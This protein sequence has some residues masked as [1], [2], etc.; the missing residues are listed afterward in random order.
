MESSRKGGPRGPFEN[1]AKVPGDH[2]GGATPVPI[3]NTEVKTTNADGTWGAAPW[4]SRTSPGYSLQLQ[5]PVPWWAA[6]AFARS[7][8][9]IGSRDMLADMASG[10]GR[11][12]GPRGP[13]A[14][15]A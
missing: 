7:E 10:S 9:Q 15:A 5:R 1:R 11:V 4:E 6:R 8:Y 12:A 13:K 14:G 3:P 2:S